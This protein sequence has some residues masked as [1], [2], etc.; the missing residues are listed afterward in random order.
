PSAMERLTPRREPGVAPALAAM[1]TI[2]VLSAGTGRCVHRFFCA[3]VHSVSRVV[4]RISG[5]SNGAQQDRDGIETGPEVLPVIERVVIIEEVLERHLTME[6]LPRTRAKLLG[7]GIT[8]GA[9]TDRAVFFVSFAC[10]C[11][12]DGPLLGLCIGEATSTNFVHRLVGIT[13]SAVSFRT[14]EEHH[15]VGVRETSDLQPM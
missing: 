12:P 11:P 9:I 7:S 10:L 5:T 13:R 2:P 4:R 8:Q 15:L 14:F 3:I 6:P 1:S